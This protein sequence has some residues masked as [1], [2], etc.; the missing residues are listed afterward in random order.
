MV[1]DRH[2]PAMV[3][4]GTP[5]DTPFRKNTRVL[6]DVLSNGADAPVMS[7]QAA[8][9]D[10]NEIVDVPETSTPKHFAKPVT[11]IYPFKTSHHVTVTSIS[12]VRGVVKA[13]VK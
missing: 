8:I 10:P 6:I 2:K 12:N 1:H 13:V 5:R 7:T 4:V 3:G 9:L 11:G